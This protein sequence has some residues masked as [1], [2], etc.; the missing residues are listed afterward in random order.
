MEQHLFSNAHILA[1]LQ[2]FADNTEVDLERVKILDITRR[3]KNLIP[4]VESHPSTLVF[5]RGGPSGHFLPHVQCSAWGSA[6]WSIMRAVSPP[7]PSAAAR[8]TT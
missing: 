8:S 6:R 3:N 1:W 4:T 5:Y 2:Y 7:A